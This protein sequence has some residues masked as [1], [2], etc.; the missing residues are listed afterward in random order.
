MAALTLEHRCYAGN[1]RVVDSLV[2][3]HNYVVKL[4]QLKSPPRDGAGTLVAISMMRSIHSNLHI[5]HNKD[6]TT[7]CYLRELSDVFQ[8]CSQ[9]LTREKTVNNLG[10]ELLRD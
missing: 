8:M 3:N 7:H 2:T 4:F 1:Y 9:T 5:R 10:L 6:R